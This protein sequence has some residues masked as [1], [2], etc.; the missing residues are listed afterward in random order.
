[1]SEPDVASGKDGEYRITGAL[2][3]A[4]GAALTYGAWS[5]A[6]KGGYAMTPAVIGPMMLALGIGLLVHGTGIAIAGINLRTRLYGLAGTAI[7][8]GLLFAY[9]FFDRPMEN[10]WLWLAESAVPFA[11]GV[12]WLLPARRLGGRPHDPLGSILAAAEAERATHAPQG[13]AQDSPPSGSSGAT[14]PRKPAT[15]STGTRRDRR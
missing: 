15:S 12:Y 2:L 13:A 8:V 6:R 14:P 7:T 3:F 4:G 10:R 11:L 9:G 1:M 5:E